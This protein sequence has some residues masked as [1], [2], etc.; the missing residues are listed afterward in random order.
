MKVCPVCG[1]RAFDDA[2][3]CF[4]CLYR[5]D[6]EPIGKNG[7]VA[8]EV[9]ASGGGSSVSKTPS[10]SSAGRHALRAGVEGSAIGSP[11]SNEEDVGAS[12]S[13]QTVSDKSGSVIRR[14]E[15]RTPGHPKGDGES[16]PVE[17]AGWTV[18][19]EAPGRLGEFTSCGAG[20]KDGRDPVEES[21]ADSFRPAPL[22]SIV[23]CIQPPSTSGNRLSEVVEERAAPCCLNTGAR[24]ASPVQRDGRVCGACR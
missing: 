24:S 23:I 4:G 16:A 11:G 7:S 14:R 18:R 2:A 5:F 9:T 8:N 22:N 20:V 3:T 10:R 12:P 19:F 17:N 21:P 1:S 15:S 6:Q 13:H